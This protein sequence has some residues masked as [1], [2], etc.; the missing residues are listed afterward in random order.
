[1]ALQPFFGVLEVPKNGNL[2][3]Y[4]ILKV[5]LMFYSQNEKE[6]ADYGITNLIHL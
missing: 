6:G 4:I 1:M 5:S 3:Q 2:K